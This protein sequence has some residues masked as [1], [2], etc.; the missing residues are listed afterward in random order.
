MDGRLLWPSC[1]ARVMVMLVVAQYIC[2]CVSDERLLRCFK[3]GGIYSLFVCLCVVV[4]AYTLNLILILVSFN[5][6]FLQIS[7]AHNPIVE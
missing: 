6:Q 2:T 5:F 1:Y 3:E 7:D 4:G